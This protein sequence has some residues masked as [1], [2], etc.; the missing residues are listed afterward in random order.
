MPTCARRDDRPG[1]VCRATR[2]RGVYSILT[3]L[4]VDRA[5][6]P[7]QLPHNRPCVRRRTPQPAANETTRRG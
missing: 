3:T 2:S 1:R 5:P 4:G 7:S 6:T